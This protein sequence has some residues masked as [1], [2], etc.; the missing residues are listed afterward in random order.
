MGWFLLVL[1]ITTKVKICSGEESFI[2]IFQESSQISSDEW[3]EFNKDFSPIIS[4]TVCHWEKLNFFNFRAS[5]VWSYCILLAKESDMECIQFGY[6]RSTATAGR[7]IKLLLSLGNR[8][9]KEIDIIKLNHRSWNHFCW[10]HDGAQNESFIT[11]NGLLVAKVIFDK[12]KVFHGSNTT[13]ATS[14]VLGQEPDSIGG[15]FD[16]QQAFRGEIA[17]LN[18]WDYPLNLEEINGM[19]TCK[20]NSQGNVVSWNQTNF[21]INNITVQVIDNFKSFCIH[22]K[23]LF[24]FPDKLSL[25]SAKQMC[26]VHGG[27]LFTPSTPEENLWLL[28]EIAEYKTKC[29]DSTTGN[30][31]W[32]G[33]K[34]RDLKVLIE[35]LEGDFEESVYANWLKTPYHA[36]NN[37]TYIDSTGQW[38]AKENCY[39]VE[40]CP[41]C[42]FVS[43]PIITLKG[44][45]VN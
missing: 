10:R 7:G 12:Q 4:F 14:L 32:L 43:S 5:Y 39:L 35:T 25:P 27:V 22:E 9:S 19:G 8:N 2:F 6:E 17:E 37:C 23:T 36:N 15:M 11:L 31:A 13:F 29:L 21:K 26:R 1:F 42:Q 38:N 45:R 40:L 41:V 16:A 34:T 3:A 28:E 20:Q 30:L 33:A 24:A 44:K 18:I